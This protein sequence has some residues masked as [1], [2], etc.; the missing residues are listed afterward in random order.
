MRDVQKGGGTGMLK[1]SVKKGCY[2]AVLYCT[3]HGVAVESFAIYPTRKVTQY[4]PEINSATTEG[5]IPQRSKCFADHH[6]STRKSNDNA[7]ILLCRYWAGHL[8]G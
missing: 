4:G 3:H 8:S 6:S 7:Y 5:K 2:S 1:D